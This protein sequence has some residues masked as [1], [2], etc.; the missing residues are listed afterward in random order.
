M[1]GLKSIV[2]CPNVTQPNVISL[3][4]ARDYHYEQC[5]QWCSECHTSY[6]TYYT[7]S[8]HTGRV[9]GGCQPEWQCVNCDMT[10]DSPCLEGICQNCEGCAEWY[11]ENSIEMDGFKH[12]D[13][14]NK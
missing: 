11:H 12:E 10:I 14:D 7:D 2:N 9:A 3:N 4:C 1:Q 13:C 8:Y 6:C 5:S